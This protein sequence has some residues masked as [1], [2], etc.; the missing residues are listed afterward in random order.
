[1]KQPNGCGYIGDIDQVFVKQEF[2]D[3]TDPA[4]LNRLIGEDQITSSSPPEP[5]GTTPEIYFTGLETSRNEDSLGG[6]MS[7]TSQAIRRRR[8]A[9]LKRR[10][11]RRFDSKSTTKKGK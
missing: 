10:K 5:T 11:A 1:M 2:M 6:T 7:V 4:E 9:S 3:L 8:Q